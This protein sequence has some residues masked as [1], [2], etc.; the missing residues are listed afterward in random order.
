MLG[1]PN[2]PVALLA[3][4]YWPRHDPQ[5]ISMALCVGYFE[6]AQSGDGPPTMMT[7]GG[8]V[9]S[10]VRWRNFE[11]VWPR[12]LH[13]EHLAAFNTHDFASGTG[14]F[15][16]D[17]ADDGP[18]RDRLIQ[19]LTRIAERHVIRAFSCS[20][21]LNDLEAINREYR[22]TESGYGP[23][24][25]CAARVIDRVHRW[26]AVRQPDDLTLFVFEDG[27]VDH[28]EIRRILT[29]DGIDRGE[30]VQLWPR[31][32]IDER[33]RQRYLRPFEACDLLMQESSSDIADRLSR[34]DAWEHEWLDREHLRRIGSALAEAPRS[35]TI[36]ALSER[37]RTY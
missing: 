21:H 25:L 17:W 16:D 33:G 37:A 13:A 18:R 4:A 27:E 30:P 9:A 19:T 11:E 14:E 22:L 15:S 6:Q 28:R 23:Y 5:H 3:S 7:V 2:W 34:R 1:D 24:G 8:F 10:K 35:D 32:W 20:V 12:A 36:S 29:A 26:M 31:H